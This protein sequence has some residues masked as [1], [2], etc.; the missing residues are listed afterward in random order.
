[1]RWSAIYPNCLLCFV[2]FC[3]RFLQ[4]KMRRK[5]LLLWPL[6]YIIIRVVANAHFLFECVDVCR[7]QIHNYDWYY[8]LGLLSKT[9]FKN[10]LSNN[11]FID[12]KCCFILTE[13]W[14]KL[15]IKYQSYP[16]STKIDA[17]EQK[18][19]MCPNRIIVI[20][21]SIINCLNMIGADCCEPEQCFLD[22]DFCLCQVSNNHFYDVEFYIAITLN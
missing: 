2:T 15:R 3:L 9:I 6:A 13:I 1:M 5:E 16:I 21:V 11:N 14:I 22:N 10:L 20:R 18:I 7:H 4:N 17:F 19:F 12:F 8:V